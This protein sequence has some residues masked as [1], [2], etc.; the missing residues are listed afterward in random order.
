MRA[1]VL[2]LITEL[3]VGGAQDNTLTTVAGLDR[4]RYEVHVAAAPGGEWVEWAGRV[5]D[6]VHLLP[7]MKREISPRHD[8]ALLR[9]LGRLYR[10][11]RY[12]IVHTHSSKAG[13]VGRLAARA[14]GV[15][16]IIH[17]VHGLP[18][19]EGMA[20]PRR[21]LYE[22]LERVASRCS[23]RIITVA[24]ANRQELIAK[25]IVDASRT[26]TIYSGI[27]LDRFSQP[28]DRARGRLA[29]EVEPTAPVVGYVARLSEQKAPLDFVAAARLVLEELPEAQFVMV[30]GGP[31]LHDVLAATGDEPSFHV[32]GQRDDVP[33]L[34]PLFDVFALSSLFEG[35]GRALTEA[36]AA[37]LPVA[38]T[39]VDGVPEIVHHE[40]TGL[41]SP[42]R[43]PDLLA[44]NIVRLLRNPAW[45]RQ[46]GRNG[47]SLVTPLFDSR[48]MVAQIDRLYQACLAKSHT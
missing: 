21:Y 48:L 2:H 46:L 6:S 1:R 17:T 40:Q 31:L 42:P 23:T 45:A 39:S 34:L 10:R 12:D 25:R 33:A 9:D 24:E 18:W 30:G 47:Q 11:E 4:E 22:T 19:Y 13:V 28:V 26:E 44:A 5:A 20:A 41:L 7:N 15:P 16:I 43:R 36:L 29:I 38:A 37:G 35:V 14:V 32:L 27:V 3:V 8:A